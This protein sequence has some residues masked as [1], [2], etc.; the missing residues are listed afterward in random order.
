MTS[1]ATA[2]SPHDLHAPPIFVH[3]VLT[4]GPGAGKSTALAAIPV[5]IEARGH[6]VIM[7]PE[8]ATLLIEGGFPIG[9]CIAAAQRGDYRLLHTFQRAVTRL[10][11]ELRENAERMAIELHAITGKRYLILHDRGI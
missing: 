1:L 2:A 4:G 5:D 7:V 8:A 11:V 10:Q 6:G 3:A 9:D